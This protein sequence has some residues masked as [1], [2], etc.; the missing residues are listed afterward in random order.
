MSE[1]T[2]P[3]STVKQQTLDGDI[4][5]LDEVNEA[6]KNKKDRTSKITISL[7]KKNTTGGDTPNRDK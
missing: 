7:N 3:D 2:K 1:Q 4:L 5:T 6:R